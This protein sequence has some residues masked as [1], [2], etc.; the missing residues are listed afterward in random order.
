MN[1][2][3]DK[4]RDK[5]EQYEKR[6]NNEG[7]IPRPPQFDEVVSRFRDFKFPGGLLMLVVLFFF[8]WNLNFFYSGY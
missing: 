7:G 2:D 5:Q 8:F 6:R 4:L 3:W 1:W